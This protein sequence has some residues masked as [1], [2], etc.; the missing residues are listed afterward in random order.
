[1]LTI[2]KDQ[3]KVEKTLFYSKIKKGALFIHPTDTIYGIGCDATNNEAVYKVR[4]TKEGVKF[5]V[6]LMRQEIR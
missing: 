4:E 6:I 1:M 5:D 2:N 3:I